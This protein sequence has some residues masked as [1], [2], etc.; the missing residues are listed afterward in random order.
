MPN[1]FV[2]SD[3]WFNRLLDDEP[4]SNIVENNDKI[5]NTWNKKI[6]KNDDVYVLGGFGIGDLYC[7]VARLNGR[8]HFLDNY[9]N[10]DEKEFMD[11]MR[12]CLE[13][14]SDQELKNRIVFEGKQI[15]VLKDKDAVLS[16]FPLAD[17]SGRKTGTYCYHGLNND[18]D[19]GEHYISCVSKRWEHIP[20]NIDAVKKNIDAFNKE[21]M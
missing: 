14:S 11:I 18:I 9:F 21:V 2:V 15:L 13:Y 12:E 5:I 17:W 6:G 10:D 16:Y 1:I 3:T 20:V 8:I 4:N 19:I 7:I